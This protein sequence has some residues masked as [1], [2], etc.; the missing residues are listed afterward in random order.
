MADALRKRYWAVM[1]DRPEATDHLRE[2]YA[3]WGEIQDATYELVKRFYAL[4]G[5]YPVV[6]DELHV[7]GSKRQTYYPGLHVTKRIVYSSDESEMVQLIYDVEGEGIILEE[8]EEYQE[9]DLVRDE[10]G[11]LVEDKD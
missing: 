5:A 9:G 8:L 11:D 4:T 6:G 7:S 1:F 2:E 3:Q 10:D